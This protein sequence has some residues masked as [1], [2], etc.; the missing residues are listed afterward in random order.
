MFEYKK[1]K[2]KY[3]TFDQLKRN[4]ILWVANRTVKDIYPIKVECLSF[5]EFDNRCCEHF[6]HFEGKDVI[7]LWMKENEYDDYYIQYEAN[8]KVGKRI[9]FINTKY[10]AKICY[11]A[12]T[13]SY[14]EGY[15]WKRV[16]HNY[17]YSYSNDCYICTTLEQAKELLNIRIK[18]TMQGLYS[19]AQDY[20]RQ[21]NEY[22][23]IYNTINNISEKDFDL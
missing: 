20:I 5:E 23:E 21:A 16:N 4:D 13:E 19:M 22:E 8:S 3:K 17:K 10:A 6:K 9:D 2:S 14:N 11:G 1:S 12:S 15:D 7:Y 18:N